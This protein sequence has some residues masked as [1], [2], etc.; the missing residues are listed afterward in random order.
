MKVTN[1][2]RSREI[3]ITHVWF[4]TDPPVHVLNPDR[5]L[6]ARLRLDETLETW[7]SVSELPTALNVERLGRIRLSSGKVVK[8]RLNKRVPPIGM[9]AGGGSK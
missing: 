4:E 8:S 5:P 1:L 9:V 6:P 7:I 3:E 2:S